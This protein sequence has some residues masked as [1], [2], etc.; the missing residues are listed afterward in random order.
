MKVRLIILALIL[1]TSCQL[2]AGAKPRT[3]RM[4]VFESFHALDAQFTT[5]DMQFRDLQNSL[6]KDRSHS[7]S[8]RQWRKTARGMQT[9]TTHISKISYRMYSQCRRP[10][11]QLRYQMFVLLHRRARAL[12]I[13]LAPVT[14]ARSR[15]LAIRDSR[16]VQNAV[17]DLVLQYQAISGGYAAASCGA[18]K[19][20]CGVEKNEPRTI[21]Y[22][23]LGVKWTCVSRASAC[24]GILGPRAPLLAQ[25]PLTVVT[26]AH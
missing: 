21:G 11:R 3:G 7:A 26:T 13:C 19:W 16:K 1:N 4:D 25:P 12:R 17:L 2:F 18:Q 10:S 22:P 8:K 6:A 23:A 20:N 24:R 15:T 5:L 14:R 9:T